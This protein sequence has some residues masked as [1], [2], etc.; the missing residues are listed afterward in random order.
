MQ[1]EETRRNIFNCHVG[2]TYEV[3]TIPHNPHLFMSCGE[4]STVRQYDLRIKKMCTKARCLEDVV[5]VTSERPVTALTVNN[6]NPYQ[7]AIGCADSYV[8]LYDRRMYTYSYS[9]PVKPIS[10]YTA[11]GMDHQ[12]SYRITSLSFSPSG[13]ELLVSYSSEH[14][15]LFAIRDQDTKVLSPEFQ[16]GRD[17]ARGSC[18]F[19]RSSSPGSS[20]PPVR[21]LRLRGDWSDTGPDARPSVESHNQQAGAMQAR[22]SLQVTLMQRMTEVLSRMLNDP[23]TRAALSH[24]DQESFDDNAPTIH[25]TLNFDDI[26]S[27][28]RIPP[29]SE[30]PRV[31]GVVIEGDPAPPQEEV[32]GH[33]ESTEGHLEVPEGDL[34]DVEE[35]PE[36]ETTPH[37]AQDTP[38]SMNVD[39]PPL[40][41]NEESAGPSTMPTPSSSSGDNHTS[42]I[43]KLSNI[44]HGLIERHGAEPMVNL[45]Y[46]P[47]G[48]TASTIS[49]SVN[50]DVK[51]LPSS[52]SS[53]SQPQESSEDQSSSSEPLRMDEDSD[54]PV[55]NEVLGGDIQD[56]DSCDTDEEITCK[57]FN[58]S[59]SERRSH[60]PL[61]E[62]VDDTVRVQ[63][64]YFKQKY[65]GHRNARTMIKEANFWG[66]NY[67]IS[68]SDC[69][70]VFM[71]E[72]SSGRL[73]M[74]LEA[75][76]HVVNCLQ[77][78]PSLPILATSG[79][80]HDVKLWAPVHETPRF[81][82]AMADELMKRN[83]LMLEETKDTITVPASFMIRML[84][85]LNQIRRSRA[86]ARGGAP[87]TGRLSE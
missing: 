54:S 46:S 25:G 82:F 33:M 58:P 10:S 35:T 59:Q 63:P 39:R 11:P 64:S 43:T 71:W 40:P 14:L 75:D 86:A 60:K 67:V 2:T 36:S 24:G 66:D 61:P 70:H 9:D 16:R 17:E 28:S 45:V 87:D 5:I 23:A 19:D 13:E 72:K 65:T 30:L 7:V 18:S 85:C 74:L 3:T 84:A 1:L 50:D 38:T 78:H 15:Y 20:F 77:P 31:E 44:C 6:A 69:G 56:E 42:S 8:R 41:T 4:D 26:S 51:R 73:K 21:R 12:R 57:P 53:S 83:A 29:D 62:E 76:R 68:G 27:P 52:S 48:S 47:K 34:E 49:V 55:E 79:I 22:P 80:D 81:D 37:L 32:V